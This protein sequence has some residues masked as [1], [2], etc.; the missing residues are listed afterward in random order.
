MGHRSISEDNSLRYIARI[1]AQTTNMLLDEI[2][3][4][5]GLIPK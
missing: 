5:K 4:L 1:I 3:I 2:N